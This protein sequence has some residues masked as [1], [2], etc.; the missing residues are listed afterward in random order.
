MQPSSRSTLTLKMN[1]AAR[2]TVFLI[3]RVDIPFK[4]RVVKKAGKNV[5]AFV[6]EAIE[7][8]L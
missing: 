5:S 3:I 4:L 1:K 2:K 7:K 6:R 8:A